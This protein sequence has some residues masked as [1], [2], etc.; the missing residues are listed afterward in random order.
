MPATFGVDE[1][2][3]SRLATGTLEGAAVGVASGTTGGVVN[4]ANGEAVDEGTRGSS[5]AEA[6][7]LP[8]RQGGLRTADDNG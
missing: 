8:G 4:E 2:D 1:V 7:R 5:D 3:L 6:N